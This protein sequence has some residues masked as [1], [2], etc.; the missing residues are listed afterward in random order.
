MRVKTFSAK[1][2][3][4]AM[5]AVRDELGDEAVIISTRES[6]SGE[7]TVLAAVETPADPVG[8]DEPDTVD[9][10]DLKDALHQALAYHGC[11]PRLCERLVKTAQRQDSVEPTLALAAAMDEIYGFSNLVDSESNNPIMLVGPPGCGKTIT[12]A[13][14]CARSRLIGK[15]AQAISTDIQRA[16]GF[17]QLAAFTRIL[18]VDLARIEEPS[19]LAGALEDA[20]GSD[21]CFIDS[22]G[23]NPYNQPDMDRLFQFVEVGKVEPVLV[24]PAGIDAAESADLARSFADLGAKR[25]I[26]TKVDMVRRAGSILAAADAAGL[27]FAE[28]SVGPQVAE[29]LT[30]LNPMSLARLITPSSREYDNDTAKA[31]AA[32]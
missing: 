5:E 1:S 17:E 24:F 18:D 11:P 27:A 13:K 31:E 21:A 10:S 12:V 32:L 28:V 30:T 4:A 20:R 22:A 6:P 3:S 14:L 29:G 2:V 8:I 7:S 23:A 9:P 19:D 16:G 26:V 15:S 25:M